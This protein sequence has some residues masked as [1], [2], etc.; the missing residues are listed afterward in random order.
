MAKPY[1]NTWINTPFSVPTHFIDVRTG[2]TMPV[3]PI[4]M[5][6]IRYHSENQTLLHLVFSA[7]THYLQSP[8]K[9]TNQEAIL[10]IKLVTHTNFL[11]LP[12]TEQ[13]DTL[14]ALNGLH[15]QYKINGIVF[16]LNFFG[17]SNSSSND[18]S[19]TEHFPFCSFSTFFCAFK[20]AAKISS[21]HAL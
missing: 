2:E 12:P 15:P 3:P 19:Q 17:S 8:R 9:Q 4:V 13:T 7:L 1:T 21:T 5:Q 6:Q 11:S 10:K 14:S 18:S 20:I 16:L